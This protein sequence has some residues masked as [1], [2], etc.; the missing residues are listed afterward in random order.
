MPRMDKI[1]QKLSYLLGSRKRIVYLVT[2]DR[3][4]L[5]ELFCAQSEVLK[6]LGG[7][8]FADRQELLPENMYRTCIRAGLLQDLRRG[9]KLN[10]RLYNF[11]AMETS[12]PMGRIKPPFYFLPNFHE[13]DESTQCSVIW[14]FLDYAEEREEQGAPAFLFLLSP[15]LKL[16]MGYRFDIQVIDVPEL[17]RE[18]VEE[19]LLQTAQSWRKTPL[20]RTEEEL[21]R[22]AAADFK[23]VAR[24][25]ILEILSTTRGLYGCFYGQEDTPTGTM[26]RRAKIAACRSE[27]VNQCKKEDARQDS[28]VTL[29]KPSPSI[30]GMQRYLSWLDRVGKYFRDPQSAAEKGIQVPKGVLLTGVPGSGKTQAAKYTAWALGND[31][32]LIPVRKEN[33]LGGYV[34]DSEANFKRLRKRAEALAP[35]VVLFDEIEKTFGSGN[36]DSSSVQNNLLAALLDWLQEN[37]QQIFFFATCNSVTELRPEL[38]RDGRFNKRFC[39]FMPTHDELKK[40][41]AFQLDYVNQ[42][43][44]FRLL[45]GFGGA[46]GE[47]P[48]ADETRRRALKTQT[49]PILEALAEEFLDKIAASA[50]ATGQD[51]FYTGANTENLIDM[52]NQALSERYPDTSPDRDTY[53]TVLLE[54]A[55]QEESQP[56][57]VTNMHDIVDFW[58]K[59]R[60]NKYISTGNF[61]PLPFG[62]FRDGKFRNLPACAHPYDQLLQERLKNYIETAARRN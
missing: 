15:V 57:G 11:D 51:L 2:E 14:Q 12:D 9:L 18:D 30:S 56:Y 42:I 3:T 61:T 40:I 46:F 58:L 6:A 21:I 59:A 19:L 17:D 48:G 32:A 52:V 49:D 36:Q 7:T 47:L 55:L 62:A 27:L 16:P 26:E 44:G 43:S 53:L 22:K 24:S 37:D 31:V 23:G 25:Q 10:E 5:K 28:T 20:R 34:G 41:I 54:V 8:A 1:T 45:S 50:K 29:L 38:L 13:L 39:A 33:I 35:A 60:L 4:F